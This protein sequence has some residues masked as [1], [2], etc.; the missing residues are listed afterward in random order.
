MEICGIVRSW[1]KESDEID[2]ILGLHILH[3][4]PSCIWQYYFWGAVND[5]KIQSNIYKIQTQI[6]H[7]D[8]VLGAH[9]FF[10]F[11]HMAC[12]LCFG[13][14]NRSAALLPNRTV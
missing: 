1:I 14:L 9:L 4:I 10:I 5:K 2:G 13:V 8:I 11:L 6:N 3:V 7:I 12:L